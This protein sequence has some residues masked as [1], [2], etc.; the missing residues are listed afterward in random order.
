[1]PDAHA[2]AF[3][4]EKPEAGMGFPG[5]SPYHVGVRDTTENQRNGV[6]KKSVPLTVLS[7]IRPQRRRGAPKA[8]PSRP[9]SLQI[10]NHVGLR[11]ATKNQRNGVVKKSVPLTVI[12]NIRPQRRRGAPQARPSRPD[13]LQIQ[14]H[15]GVRGPAEN[16]RNGVVKKSVPLTVLSNIRPQRRRGAPKARPSRPPVFIRSQEPAQRVPSFR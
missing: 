13:S 14:N 1:M 4:R 9:D 2:S 7:N 16:Q 10:Q 11:D 3:E 5:G 12:T 8:R 6:V 15:V